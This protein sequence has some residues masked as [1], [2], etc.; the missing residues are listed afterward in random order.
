MKK[1][2]IFGSTGTIGKH[3]LTQAL[4]ADN[5]VTAFC[6]NKSNLEPTEHP[7]LQI[8]EGDV[9]NLQQVTDSIRT[10]KKSK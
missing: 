10:K 3:I 5:Q 9:R 7:N 8:V 1:T 2:I 6:R 4:A